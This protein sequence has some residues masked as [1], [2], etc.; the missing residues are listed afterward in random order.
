LGTDYD[1][2]WLESGSL[3]V[4]TLGNGATIGSEKLYLIGEK[5]YTSDDACP[6]PFEDI[7][8]IISKITGVNPKP[9][10]TF[11][12]NDNISTSCGDLILEGQSRNIRA[13]DYTWSLTVDGSTFLNS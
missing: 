1:C 11:R 6:H 4:I 3:L 7:E 13:L 10:A 2:K 9:I 8:P 5:L 12:I